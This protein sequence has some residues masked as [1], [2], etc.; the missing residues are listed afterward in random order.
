VVNLVVKIDELQK[1]SIISAQV[2]DSP[3]ATPIISSYPK[4]T[5]KQSPTNLPI[6]V[7]QY[8][9]DKNSNI[10]GKYINVI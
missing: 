8:D 3:S 5:V 6:V 4:Y 9:Y 10:K 2:A 7:K 1:S